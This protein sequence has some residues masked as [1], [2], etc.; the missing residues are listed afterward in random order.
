[1]IALATDPHAAPPPSAWLLRHAHLIPPGSRIL[2]L[3]CG[4]GRHVRWLA[5]QGQ[6]VTAV[7]RDAQALSTLAG[8]PGVEILVHDLEAQGW[9][10]TDRRFDLVLVTN[11][12]WR[13]LL[14]QVAGAVAEAGLLIY[15]TF[16]WAQ[17]RFGRPRNPDFLLR[18]G[19]LIETCQQQGL[20]VLAFEDG[21]EHLDRAGSVA[22]PEAVG[23]NTL[24]HVQRVVARR[25]GPGCWGEP[26]PLDRMHR[27]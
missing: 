7:D 15:E 27:F 20:Q 26:A 23:Q 14:P 5:G 22:A 13:P 8:L 3:A 25:C 19:E 11:Y 2:D 18:P 9:P 24:R 1:M 6:R 17:T 16:G 21:L 10:W 4:S 12:L